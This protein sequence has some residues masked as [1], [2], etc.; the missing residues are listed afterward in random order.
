MEEEEEEDKFRNVTCR[1]PVLINSIIYKI[2][3]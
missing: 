3:M 1:Y 2:I